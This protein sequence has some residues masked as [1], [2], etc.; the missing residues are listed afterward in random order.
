M[1]GLL[2]I[3]FGLASV[4]LSVL[5]LAQDFHALTAWVGVVVGLV[6]MLV[7]TQTYRRWRRRFVSKREVARIF[8]VSER[9]VEHWLRDGK[10]PKPKRKLG[11]RRWNYEELI[12]LRKFKPGR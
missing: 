9:T 4:V 8:G 12:A 5:L 7:G 2:V 6:A 3:F 10:L 1:T 11:L